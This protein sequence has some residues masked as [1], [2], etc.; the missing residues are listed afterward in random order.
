MKSPLYAALAFSL[1]LAAILLFTLG[2]LGPSPSHLEKRKIHPPTPKK[3]QPGRNTPINPLKR[4]QTLTQLPLSQAPDFET[5]D[6][7]ASQLSDQELQDLIA[8]SGFGDHTRLH[9]WLRCAL[10]AEWGRRDHEAALAHLEVHKPLP[11]KFNYAF[12]Q[13]LFSTLRGWTETDPLAAAL[14][15]ENSRELRINRIYDIASEHL[16][17][18]DPERALE[19]GRRT[20]N[21]EYYYDYNPMQGIFRGLESEET[22]NKA[23]D[24][25][26]ED[27]WE[28]P[29]TKELINTLQKQ[30]SSS[31]SSYTPTPNA[32]AVFEEAALALAD[33]DFDQAIEFIQANTQRGEDQAEGTIS[34]TFAKWAERNPQEALGTLR[35]HQ[36]PEYHS[37][38]AVGIL[39][40]DLSMASQVLDLFSHDNQKSSLIGYVISDARADFY[41][42]DFFP[43]PDQANSLRDFQQ[44][45]SDIRKLIDNASLQQDS[46]ANLLR[47]LDEKFAKVLSN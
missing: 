10:Y 30:L 8:E 25:W 46:R 16:A 43:A 35:A 14:A 40:N 13:A 4:L 3:S 2:G 1:C 44:D 20:A 29:H 6:H 31:F 22:L 27:T 19:L 18:A 36:Y 41:I 45:Y 38:L 7:W 26:L 11:P 9:G 17:T 42:D 47:S 15:L 24:F 23:I 28:S 21:D 37:E 33:H 12:D 34:D 39:A 5:V 32:V